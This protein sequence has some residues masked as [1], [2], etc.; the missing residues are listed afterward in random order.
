MTQDENNH[1]PC[2]LGEDRLRE[3]IR[4]ELRWVIREIHENPPDPMGRMFEKANDAMLAFKCS[5][6]ER[7]AEMRR[8]EILVE[9]EIA[10]TQA[11]RDS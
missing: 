2:R 7:K 5:M 4:Q 3:I 9:H 10:E 11:S 1:G 6:I 8:Q